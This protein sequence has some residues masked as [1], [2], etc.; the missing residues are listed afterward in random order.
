ML[1]ASFEQVFAQ[2]RSAT[3]KASPLFPKMPSLSSHFHFFS[4]LIPYKREGNGFLKMRW[5]V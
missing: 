1:V 5:E 3:V 4:L 2:N